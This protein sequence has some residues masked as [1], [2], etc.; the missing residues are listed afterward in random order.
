MDI[1][2]ASED[3]EQET[4]ANQ[5]RQLLTIDE[6]QRLFS[7]ESVHRFFADVF[8]QYQF[9]WTIRLD[10]ATNHAHV[11]QSLK[12]LI[13]PADK[14]IGSEKIRQ[15]LGHE[16]ET[17]VFRAVSGGK[18]SMALLSIGLA[19][20]LETEEGLAIYYTQEV[21]KYKGSG[22]AE[23]S[24]I[25]TLATGLAAKVRALKLRVYVTPDCKSVL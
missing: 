5:E 13:L 14:W 15:L 18:S 8:Q 2:Y 6:S 10:P 22:K 25:G 12:Q 24:W 4:L 1:K 17:H 7:P 19:G 11:S 16:I 3:I 23:K 21:D 20:Y 9:P